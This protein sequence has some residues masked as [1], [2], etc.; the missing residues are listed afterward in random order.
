[1]IAAARGQA[2]GV[3]LHVL[4][5]FVVIALVISIH[6]AS[7]AARVAFFKIV[8][9]AG[10]TAFHA[11]LLVAVVIRLGGIAG[12]PLGLAFVAALG[13][14]AAD[15][16]KHLAVFAASKHTGPTVARA[17]RAFALTA[18]AASAAALASVSNGV[19]ATEAGI[20]IALI[21]ITKLPVVFLIGAR[22][23]ICGRVLV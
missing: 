7:A 22:F 8:V 21:R 11:F 20:G 1:V 12:L 16:T 13:F 5:S 6:A 15:V 14:A 3:G 10:A 2:L 23:S 4:V 9:E 17:W 18:K 19:V